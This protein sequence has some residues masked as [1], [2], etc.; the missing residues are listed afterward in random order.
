MGI[1]AALAKGGNTSQLLLTLPVFSPAG[2]GAVASMLVGLYL[3]LRIR[4][5]WENFIEQ[6]SDLIAIL[7]LMKLLI[8]NY[9]DELARFAQTAV[10]IKVVVA[11]LTEGGLGWL[12][13]GRLEGVEFIVGIDLGI[14]T[15]G[16]LKELQNRGVTVRVFREPGKLFHPKIIYFRSDENETLIVGSNNLTSGGISSNHE[17][18]LAIDRNRESDSTFGDFLAYFESLKVHQCCGIPDDSFYATYVPSSLSTQLSERLRAQ[19]PMHFSPSNGNASD[20]QD[21]R[22][23]TLGDYIRL[24]A[25]EFPNLERRIE[26]TVKD[27]PLKILNDEEF[28][29]LFKDIVSAV[30]KGRLIGH[31]Q[32]NI[33]GQ[34]YR[35]PN[36]LAVNDDREP[37]GNTSSRGRLILQIHFSEDYQ[38]V[39]ISIVLQYSLHRS[40]DAGEMPVEAADRYR[41][42]LQYLENYSASSKLDLPVFRHWNY[43]GTVLWGKPILSF[44]HRVAMLPDD[45]SLL[46]E[47]EFLARVVNGASAVS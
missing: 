39:F 35:I 43:K 7:I 14:T 6:T 21:A 27:H 31:A 1:G 30:S 11:F 34:W 13:Q 2:I 20:I 47:M 28:L 3:G 40:L 10:E 41:K 5:I 22:T 18:S 46:K 44:E 12:P 37:W 24:V 42:L 38:K 16:A 8:Q 26:G 29:P 33:G 9:D 4:T 25:K 23:S 45:S 19:V 15:P 36:I 32:L 17:V